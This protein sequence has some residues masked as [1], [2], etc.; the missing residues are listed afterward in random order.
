ML[1]LRDRPRVGFSLEIEVVVAA[2]GLV[3]GEHGIARFFWNAL[4]HL[5]SLGNSSLAW[6]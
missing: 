4:G 3:L 1:L 5:H 2:K 6:N